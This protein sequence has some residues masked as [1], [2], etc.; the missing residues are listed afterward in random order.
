[1]EVV[2]REVIQRK[3]LYSGTDLT[4]SELCD[5]MSLESASGYGQL[6]RTATSDG[7]QILTGPINRVSYWYDMET[8]KE[9]SARYAVY[10]C[11]YAGGVYVVYYI[12]DS[13]D[14]ANASEADT[15]LDNMWY[16]CLLS[17][18]Q[19]RKPDASGFT[20][21]R[22][23]FKNGTEIEFAYAPDRLQRV[24]PHD[25]GVA[26]NLYYSD[27]DKE[28]VIVEH[29]DGTETVK[30]PDDYYESVRQRLDPGKYTFTGVSDY[31]GYMNYR[32]WDVSYDNNG[33]PYTETVATCTD[34]N[35][36]II[37]V[38]WFRPEEYNKNGNVLYY[39]V[40]QSLRVIKE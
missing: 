18:K 12:L 26:V 39:Q 30:T 14:Y 32:K 4:N 6:V 1:M 36:G 21:Q 9:S 22:E 15:K 7:D 33:V 38:I 35:G 28:Y 25:N 27:G 2:Y 24:L 20:S 31:E 17:L 13:V 34:P 37:N 5:V 3:Y 29:Y 19:L 11:K 16:E 8:R 23:V 40:L 10:D